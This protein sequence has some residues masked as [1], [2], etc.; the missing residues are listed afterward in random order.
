MHPSTST[1]WPREYIYKKQ[2]STL[3]GPGA[4]FATVGDMKI[5]A[6]PEVIGEMT[7]GFP[8]LAWKEEGLATQTVKSRIFVQPSAR[9]I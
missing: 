4:L 8:S 5:L 1:F 2:L 7:K 6:L 9:A 3:N